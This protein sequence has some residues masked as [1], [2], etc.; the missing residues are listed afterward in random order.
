M[1][2][3]WK[4]AC[5]KGAG[6]SLDTA[7]TYARVKLTQR[8]TVMR[9]SYYIKCHTYC[10][11]S[12]QPVHSACTGWSWRDHALFCIVYKHNN[13]SSLPLLSG[14]IPQLLLILATVVA[15]VLY[16]LAVFQCSSLR[17]ERSNYTYEFVTPQMATSFTASLISFVII[18]ILNVL[19]EKVAVWIT[20]CGET[21]P[22]VCC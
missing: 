7:K 6:S 8:S 18:T 15:I 9:L 21:E 17:E 22:L 2:L 1:S 10:T 5:Q 14:S 19:Y 4:Y 12:L 11:S 3:F 16:R 13:T 20:N